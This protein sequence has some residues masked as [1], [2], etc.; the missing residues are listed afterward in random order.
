M[1]YLCRVVFQY[2]LDNNKNTLNNTQHIPFIL[3]PLHAQKLELEVRDGTLT[4]LTLYTVTEK[5][6]PNG[7]DLINSHK[8]ITLFTYYKERRHLNCQTYT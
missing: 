5:K 8:S 3:N 7:D 4:S 1:C 6:N 2:C